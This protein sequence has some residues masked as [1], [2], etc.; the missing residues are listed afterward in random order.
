[1]IYFLIKQEI[2]SQVQFNLNL[3]YLNESDFHLGS[4]GKSA[5]DEKATDS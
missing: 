3:F 4:A 5:D 1:M 2:Q